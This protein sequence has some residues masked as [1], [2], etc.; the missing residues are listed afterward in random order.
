MDSLV[1]YIATQADLN[2]HCMHVAYGQILR[3]APIIAL[4]VCKFIIFY[5][6]IA[7]FIFHF[8]TLLHSER[9]ELYPILAFL[10]A[11]CLI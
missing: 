2:V 4:K 10:S 6:I 11:I 1:S 9:P 8:L 7:I 3:A 5:I